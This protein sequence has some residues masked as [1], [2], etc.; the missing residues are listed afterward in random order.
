MK[1][2]KT[3]LPYSKAVILLLFIFPLTLVVAQNKTLKQAEG[4]KKM[5]KILKDIADTANPNKVFFLNS[6]RAA[7]IKKQMQ[8]LGFEKRLGMQGNYAYELLQAGK[9]VEAI[10]LLED[11]IKKADSLNVNVGLKFY[12]LLGIAYMRLGEQQNCCMRHTS[13][14]CIIPIK[15][16]G[17]HTMK[18]GSLKAIALYEKLLQKNPEELQTRW[19]LNVAYM[20]LGKYPDGVPA[21]YLIP[22]KDSETYSNFPRWKD[23]A[24][25]AGVAEN[26]MLGGACTEDFDQDGF[27]DILCTSQG[28]TDQVKLFHNNGDGTFKEMSEEAGITGIVGG[29]NLVHADYNN[30][31]W[32]DVFIVR[33]GWLREGGRLPNSLLQNK[34]DGTFEDVTIEAGLLSYYPSQTAS[35]ADFNN[36]GFLDLFVG[37]ESDGSRINPCELFVNNKNGTFTNVAKQLQLDIVGFVKGASWGDINNDGLP[38]LYLSLINGKNKLFLN[39][40]G[41]ALS[42]WKFEDISAAAKVEEPFSSFPCWFFDYNNDGWEDIF[43]SGYSLERLNQVGFDAANEYLGKKALA[44]TP[45]L[46]KNNKD[47]TF[48]DVSVELGFENRVV[49]AMGVNYGD[50]DNDGWLDFYLGTGSPDYRSISPNRM[51]HN[52]EGKFFSEVTY[53]GG[54]AHIQK[55]HSVEFADINNDG[56][57]DIYLEIGGGVEGDVFPNVLFENPGNNNKWIAL[58]LEGTSSN[59]GAVG[60]RIKI[61]VLTNENKQREIYT[62]CSTGGSFGSSSIQQEIGLG[63]ATRIQAIE[64]VFPDGKNKVETYKNLELN[65]VYRLKQGDLLPKRLERKTFSFK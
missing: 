51:F 45:R 9:T 13:E 52:D 36:D 6:K 62:T 57:Q 33:G 40:G 15:G 29:A 5:A 23:V 63:D 43:V 8:G 11:F 10:R 18:E 41:S 25:T 27:I 50:L 2:Y 38:D 22:L 19:L 31:G 28:L 64:I 3:L 42:D 34:G 47:N 26:G 12:T 56:D 20:T 46:Y 65:N 21:N 7:A 35:W 59:R 1:F 39:K 61:T 32:Q 14:S 53:S 4:T 55:G 48:T 17:I 58:L 24:P 54:F 30:D 44:Q 60:A 49:Y 16:K 37:N